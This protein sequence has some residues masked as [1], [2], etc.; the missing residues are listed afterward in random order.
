[1]LNIGA[2]TFRVSRI[3]ISRPD[4]GATFLELAPSLLMNEADLAA[5][6]LVQPGS[7]VR[8]AQLFAGDRSEIVDFKAWL[9]KNKKPNEEIE[10]VEDSAP[11]IKSAMDR[12]SQFP[13]SPVS[14]RCCCARSRW[15]WPRGATCNGI[16]TR[17]R[18]SRLSARRADSLWR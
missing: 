6:E 15:P 7:R 14:S 5:T 12:S 13:A 17:W 9:E 1:V 11:Q 16:S 8:R 10:D 2:S 18:C 3:L 4:Q